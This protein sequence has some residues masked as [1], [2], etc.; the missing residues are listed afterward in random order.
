MVG[1]W[2]GQVVVRD[3]DPVPDLTITPETAQTAEGGRL[4]WSIAAAEST[5]ARW[6]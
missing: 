4:T 6:I 2:Q 3:D 1:A 5:D